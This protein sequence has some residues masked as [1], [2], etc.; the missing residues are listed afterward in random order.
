[1]YSDQSPNMSSMLI[2]KIDFETSPPAA[3]LLQKLYWGFQ[4]LRR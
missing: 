3:D 4:R 1:M 2:I